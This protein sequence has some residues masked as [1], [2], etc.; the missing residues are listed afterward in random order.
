MWGYICI[1]AR[2]IFVHILEGKMTMEGKD[3]EERSTKK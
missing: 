1:Y 2:G 3:L